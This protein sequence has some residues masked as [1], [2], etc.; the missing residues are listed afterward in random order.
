MIKQD[1]RELCNT[2]LKEIFDTEDKERI[3]VT[4]DELYSLLSFYDL[5]WKDHRKA[6]EQSLENYNVQIRDKSERLPRYVIDRIQVRGYLL[7]KIRNDWEAPNL[8]NSDI[9]DFELKKAQATELKFEINN[10]K[11]YKRKSKASNITITK[12]D[13]LEIKKYNYSIDHHVTYYRRIYNRFV[14]S[15]VYL[16][17]LI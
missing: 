16:L 8:E 13:N 7:W 1:I 17:N 14:L 12:I 10:R 3:P 6:V 4:K 11:I 15:L 9:A 2:S 5:T